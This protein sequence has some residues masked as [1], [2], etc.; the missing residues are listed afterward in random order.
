M[1]DVP[2]QVIDDRD[3]ACIAALVLDPIG[4]TESRPARRRA[5]SRDSPRRWYD[6]SCCG[7]MK[8]KLLIE[9]S[10]DRHAL[11]PSGK[12]FGRSRTSPVTSREPVGDGR[13][14]RPPVP[15]AGL[16]L[17]PAGPCELVILRAAA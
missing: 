5:S 16:E 7:A 14:E 17:P 3:A 4:F 15:L 1:A 11:A 12:G 10:L 8:S 9:L 13:R 6:S 2:E